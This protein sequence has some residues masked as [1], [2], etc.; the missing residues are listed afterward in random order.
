MLRGLLAIEP[1][2]PPCDVRNE[3]VSGEFIRGLLDSRYERAGIAKLPQ[4]DYIFI[5]YGLND[6]SKRKDFETNFPQDFHELIARLRKDHPSAML[7][8]TTVIPFGAD[9]E[10]N[11]PSAKRI[12][13]LVRRVAEEEKLTLFDLYPRYAAELARGPNML[14]YRRY[15]LAKMPENLRALAMPYISDPAAKDPTI[16]VMDNHL[17]AIFGHLPGW[18]A[19]R[20]PN[21]AGYNVI[22]SATAKFLA[23]IVRE[24]SAAQK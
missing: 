16:I 1:G 24:K 6:A 10:S 5:R 9:V 11:A 21:L 22:A 13:D 4:A 3:G 17:D 18:F 8:P 19:D 14:S 12:N 23:P 15:A 20:H 2:L 7:I